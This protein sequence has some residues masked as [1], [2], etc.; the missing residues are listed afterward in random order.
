MNAL[1]RGPAAIVNVRPIL[2]SERM[3]YKDYD[4]HLRKE[5]LATSLTGL[6]AKTN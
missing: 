3:L 4:R 1:A 5:I 6:A 2:S